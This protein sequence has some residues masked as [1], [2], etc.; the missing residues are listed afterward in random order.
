M[1][2][3]TATAPKV[4]ETKSPTPAPSHEPCDACGVRSFYY[5][6]VNGTVMS[7]CSHHATKYEVNLLAVASKIVDLRYMVSP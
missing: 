4:T 2:T 7:Y 6:T 5:A 3:A 1:T